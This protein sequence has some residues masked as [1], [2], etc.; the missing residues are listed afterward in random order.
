MCIYIYVYIYRD[1]MQASGC[2]G[3]GVSIPPNYKNYSAFKR[4]GLD[5]LHVHL[6]EGWDSGFSRVLQTRGRF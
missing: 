1:R 2:R 4:K 6:E 3:F 5:G